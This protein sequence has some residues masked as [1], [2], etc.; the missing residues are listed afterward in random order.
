VKIRC[1]T[2]R[3]D[4]ESFA[5][6]FYAEPEPRIVH[7]RAVEPPRQ[8]PRIIRPNAPAAPRAILDPMP[9]IY[10]RILYLVNGVQHPLTDDAADDT[11][12]YLS[13]LISRTVL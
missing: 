5:L 2:E 13:G 3:H 8:P 11:R 7:P 9:R 4:P 1:E 10:P 6:K 12:L